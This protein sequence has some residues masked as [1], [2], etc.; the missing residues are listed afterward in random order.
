[1]D[2]CHHN[3]YNSREYYTCNI[4]S[5]IILLYKKYISNMNLSIQIYILTRYSIIFK[6]RYYIIWL[7]FFL[8]IGGT[9]INY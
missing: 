7:K 5:A 4:Y 8:K 3:L 2:E 9:M 1:M 6:K